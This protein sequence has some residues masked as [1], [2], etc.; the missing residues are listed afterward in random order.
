MITFHRPSGPASA[1]APDIS[2]PDDVVWIDL[3]DASP[4]EVETVGRLTD[5]ALPT[6]DELREVERSSRLRRQKDAL[7]MSMPLAFAEAHGIATTPVGFV[8]T[9]DRL[10]TIRFHGAKGFDMCA[11]RLGKDWDGPAPDAAKV[12]IVLLESLV[13]RLADKLEEIGDGLDLLAG[14]VFANHAPAQARPPKVKDAVLRGTMGRIGRSGQALGKLRASLLA[15]GRMAPYLEAEAREWLDESARSHLDTL[16]Q[17]IASLDEYETHLTDKVQFLLDAAL[18][19]INIEQNN[20]FK[21]LTIASV[22][23]IPPTLVASMYGMN[24]RGM[25]ELDWA[26]GYPYALALILFSAVIPAIWF[27]WKGWF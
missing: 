27:K 19:L 16:R 3:R 12:L 4:A 7:V 6:F 18:G 17:D 11:E 1:A 10:I 22:I 21:V 25:P 15:I 9:K 5:F 26:W 23:G 13:D 14:R 20:T 2:L 24:F 8:L